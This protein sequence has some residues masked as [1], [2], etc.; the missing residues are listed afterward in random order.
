MIE[1]KSEV[2]GRAELTKIKA[3]LEPP[4]PTKADLVR[5]FDESQ[6]LYSGS[7][8]PSTEARIAAYREREANETARLNEIQA[9]E[10]EARRRGDLPG[11]PPERDHDLPA[12][13]RLRLR[14]VLRYRRAWSGRDHV[15][16]RH[17]GWFRCGGGRGGPRALCPDADERE[18]ILRIAA[19]IM[20]TAQFAKVREALR[21]KSQHTDRLTRHQ[22]AGIAARALGIP[23]DVLLDSV[24]GAT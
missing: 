4:A 23:T 18:K 15:R 24:R 21:L 3:A 19:Q 20:D 8:Y 11:F 22:I 14:L 12:R 6:R 13:R 9:S 17:L 2:A 7:S 1:A 5:R 10:Q 16:G